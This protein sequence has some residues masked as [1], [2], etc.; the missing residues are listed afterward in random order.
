MATGNTVIKKVKK[1]GHGG[2]HGGAWKVAY[3]D[4]VT[5]M[6]AFF[7]LLW[8]LNAVPST[9][10][11]GVADYFTPTMGLKDQ[12]GIGFDGGNTPKTKGKQ[13]GEWTNN[14]II[15][16]SPPSGAVVKADDTAETQAEVE[17]KNFSKLQNDVYKAMQDGNGNTSNDM[18]DSMRIEQ[19]PEGIR[20]KIMDKN[21]KSMFEPGTATLEPYAKNTLA[22]I[23]K[24]ARYLPNYISIS[25]HTSTTSFGSTNNYDP[26]EL[27]SMR[28]NETRKFLISSGMDKE[29]IARIIGKADQ[30]PLDS[31]D[32]SNIANMRIEI[33]IL[34][35]TIL[36]YQKR[37]APEDADL[38]GPS[39]EAHTS[40]PTVHPAASDDKKSEKK[41]K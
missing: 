29:Q 27:S 10:L 11:Q 15:Y 19:T 31:Q 30:E 3:A 33:L 1:G 7:L 38:T 32:P 16:G 35:N 37:A 13:K 24:I 39:D 34:K 36:P 6:M 18:Q 21:D 23:A 40:H 17:A 9:Q 8:L 26:W 28:A 25:G 2:A 5:A 41:V 12:M 4:F 20:I 14:A 22:K